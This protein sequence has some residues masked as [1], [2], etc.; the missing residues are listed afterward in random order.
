APVLDDPSLFD[1]AFFGY[2]PY[3]AEIIDPQHRLFLECAWTALEHAGYD[4]ARCDRPVGVFGGSAINSYLLFG[5]ALQRFADHYFLTLSGSDQDFLATRV[6]YKL[7]LTGP[8]MTVQTACS[9]SLVAVH[10]AKQSLLDG[11]CDMALAG[12]V[13]VRVPH[14]VG[15]LHA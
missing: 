12:G 14:R 11:E 8:S 6:S 1:A 10:L 15:H 13:A 9:T 2:T 5:G 4:P 7:N 3:E